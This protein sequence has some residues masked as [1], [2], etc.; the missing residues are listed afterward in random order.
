MER[1][2]IRAVPYL[3]A[4]LVAALPLLLVPV[5]ADPLLLFTVHL[6]A[7]VALAVVVAVRLAPLADEDWFTDRGWSMLLSRLAAA[8][9]VIVL[10]T[11]LGALVTLAT[12]AA[13]RYQP[14][15]QFLQ[16]LSVLDIAWAG[17]AIVIGARRLWGDRAGIA[18]GVLLGVFCVWS[19]WNY[20][21]TV[22]FETD[23]GWLV[24]GDEIM[25]LV[26]PYDMAAAVVA[27]V[28]LVAGS[29]RAASVEPLR[30]AT[31]QARP[32]S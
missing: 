2:A 5:P 7:V 21:N 29:R 20:L 4:G 10:V 1:A 19:I 14:S 28:L 8:I 13:L 3:V 17:A 31:E 26:M 24:R 27:V 6:S 18:G 15:L 32:Q 9:V 30:Q 16:L 25:R 11:G 23:G 22:G 12:S